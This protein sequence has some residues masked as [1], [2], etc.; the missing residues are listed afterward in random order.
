MNHNVTS[1]R[2]CHKQ[3]RTRRLLG[4]LVLLLLVWGLSYLTTNLIPSWWKSSSPSLPPTE[5]SLPTE[6]PT[7]PP[8]EP[9]TPPPTEPPTDPPT[10]PWPSYEPPEPGVAPEILGVTEDLADDPFFDLTFFIGDSITTMLTAFAAFDT[11]PYLAEIG[12]TLVRANLA[13]YNFTSYDPRHIF[14]LLGANDLV[15]SNLTTENFLANYK[16]LILTLRELFPQAMVYPQS[17][18]PLAS[19]HPGNNG[20]NNERILIFNLALAEFCR[21]QEL[22]FVDIGQIWRLPDS[23]L[24]PLIT[25][26]GLH[27]NYRYYG[28]W[29]QILKD[30]ALIATARSEMAE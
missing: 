10:I 8:T 27:I 21:E 13:V 19:F 6:P 5:A 28:S 12:L 4:L 17:I 9:P 2:S 7:P 29:L 1:Y 23:S 22:P 25:S 24:H 30:Y 26:D 11:R 16:E 15:N 3:R 18:L 20:L 14:I